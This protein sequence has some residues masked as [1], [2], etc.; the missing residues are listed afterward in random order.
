MK[1]ANTDNEKGRIYDVGA[2]ALSLLLIERNNPGQLKFSTN[3]L[4]INE[5]LNCFERVA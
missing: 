5:Q 3:R 1:T 2:R 4:S